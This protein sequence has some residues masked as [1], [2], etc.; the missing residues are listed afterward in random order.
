MEL[1]TAPVHDVTT[2][3]HEGLQD[4]V[5]VLGQ[6]HF[7]VSVRVR[8]MLIII[9]MDQTYRMKGPAADITPCAPRAS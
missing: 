7:R 1:Y 5:R 4:E 8:A 6:G 2:T 3:D 9:V